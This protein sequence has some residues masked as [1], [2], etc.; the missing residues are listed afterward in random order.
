VTDTVGKLA[1]VPV[2]G[3]ASCEVFGQPGALE[4][5]RLH[6]RSRVAPLHIRPGGD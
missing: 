3:L 4:R 2:L 6:E 1:A 5:D